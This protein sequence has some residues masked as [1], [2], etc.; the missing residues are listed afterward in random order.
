MAERA[1]ASPGRRLLRALGGAVLLGLG[2]IGAANAWMIHAGAGATVASVAEAPVR[3]VAIVLGNRVFSDGSVS[4][5]LAARIRVGLELYQAK[6]VQKLFLS[7]AHYPE[8]GYDE[9]A[10]MA[11]W[12][13]RRGV[14]RADLILDE[15]GHR[16]AATMANAAALGFREVLVCTQPYHLPRSIFLARHAGLVPIG[17][18]AQQPDAMLSIT[19]HSFLRETMARAEIIAE[20]AWRGVRAH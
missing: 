13:E 6:K 20:V 3:P 2:A 18:P 8:Q 16:T 19:V 5:E 14:P 7:G 9:P 12:L 17:V 1:P 4:R 10:A 15:D 11:G